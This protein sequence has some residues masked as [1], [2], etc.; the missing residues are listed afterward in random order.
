MQKPIRM[1]DL[2]AILRAARGA[3]TAAEIAERLGAPVR[4]VYRD[5]AALQAMGVPIDGAA[6][7]G[8]ILRPGFYLPP[9]NFTSEETE[10]ITVALALPRRTGDRGLSAA[11]D[12]VA[13]KVAAVQPRPVAT[14]SLAASPWHELP[15][16]AVDATLLRQAV[17]EQSAVTITYCDE[18]G[19]N[20]ERL[21]L[22][23]FL[24][25]Y[26]EITLI[27]AYCELRQDFRHF[28]LDRVLSARFE[29]TRFTDRAARLRQTWRERHPDIR[30]DQG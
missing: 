18:F 23:L 10:A 27:A 29:R 5:V 28:R 30:F 16:A 24:I 20:T 11:A 25:Y 22:P 3:L 2:I 4:T 7:L 14:A 26:V 17:R 19:N 15:A 8:Y 21:I 13:A 1:L 6:G 12:S 9:L